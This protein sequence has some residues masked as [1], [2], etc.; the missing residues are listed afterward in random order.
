MEH[1]RGELARCGLAERVRLTGWVGPDEAETLLETADVLVLPSFDENLPMSVIEGMGHAL[2]VVT[3]PVGA[4]ADIIEDG[5]T[6]LLVPPGDVDRLAD[7]LARLVA[8]P[9]LRLQLGS[10][11]RAFHRAHLNI[12]AYLP[13]LMQIWRMAAAERQAGA[14]GAVL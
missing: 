7:A 11:A 4:V 6:G 13:R 8:D 2:A 10:R 5:E 3:T 12:D 14:V 9:G 1:T